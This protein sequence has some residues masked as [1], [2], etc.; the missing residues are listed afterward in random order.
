MKRTI[1]IAALLA[2]ASAPHLSAADPKP[3]KGDGA[4]VVL[5]VKVVYN[6]KTYEERLLSEDGAQA[7]S[8]TAVADQ[9]V[10]TV[11]VIPTSAGDSVSVVT[12]VSI[13]ELL[14]K[15]TLYLREQTV[16]LKREAWTMVS[17]SPAAKLQMRVSTAAGEN[18]IPD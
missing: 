4:Q 6:G 12:M 8:V 9:L 5:E 17:S 11:N 7:K 14:S 2:L 3:S 1:A 10:M 18:P 16:N 13:E 15:R